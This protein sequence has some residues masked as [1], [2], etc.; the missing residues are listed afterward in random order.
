M[1]TKITNPLSKAGW[2]VLILG[3]S[4]IGVSSLTSLGEM[5][6]PYV[7]HVVFFCSSF[8]LFWLY[9]QV[10]T[11]EISMVSQSGFTHTY[12]RKREPVLF[13]LVCG[14]IAIIALTLTVT[15]GSEIFFGCEGSLINPC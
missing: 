5:L 15:L 7:V 6:K 9:F 3:F 1:S 13:F 2:C 8:T 11:G 12:S 14:M 10:K 4:F